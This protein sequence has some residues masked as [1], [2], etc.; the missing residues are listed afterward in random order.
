MYG[1]GGFFVR[2]ISKKERNDDDVFLKLTAVQLVFCFIAF[3]AVFGVMKLNSELFESFREEFSSLNENDL[4]LGSYSFFDFGSVREKKEND[5]TT[6]DSDSEEDD[7]D[8]DVAAED[9]SEAELAAEEPKESDN[10]PTLGIS[11]G[12]E[13]FI[14]VLSTFY[15]N[16]LA[17]MPVNG[18][19]T[20]HYGERTDP[21]Y[22]GESFH[23]GEDI[24]ANEGTPVYAALDGTVIDVGIGAKS[25][26]Y[27][28]ISHDD[29]VET[30][31]CHL[32]NANVDKGIS[33]RRGDIIGF[34]GQTGFATGPHLHFEVKINGQKTDPQILLESAAVVS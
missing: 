3:V 24:A 30:L 9:E 18:T 17:V 32:K 27:V 14:G 21:I 29:S 22:G 15:D 2:K 10:Q 5:K 4:D 12:S 26:N 6:E 1:Q 34:V 28:K 13:E 33:V 25:G 20:S 16:S 19:V 7:D 31:Y 11:T 23:A 8:D